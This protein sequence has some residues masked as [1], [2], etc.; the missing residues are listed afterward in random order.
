MEGMEYAEEMVIGAFV[1]G[2]PLPNYDLQRE[3]MRE[4]YQRQYSTGFDYAYT[5]PVMAKIQSAGRVIRPGT[6]C[7]L[8]VL[9]DSRFMETSY[10]LSMP[11]DWFNPDVT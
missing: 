9:M 7:G 2:L 3:Q 8:I 6:D 10:S 5:I 4:Y 1:I 11:V